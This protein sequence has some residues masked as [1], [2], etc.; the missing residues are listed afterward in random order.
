[1]NVPAL[2]HRSEV[3]LIFPV[4]Q[5]FRE[6]YMRTNLLAFIAMIVP[7][8]VTNGATADKP[9]VLLIVCDDLNRHVSTSGYAPIDT[10]ALESLA[11]AG[12]NFGRAYCQYPVCGPSRAS[13]L[14]GLYPETTR[15]LDNK[16]DIRSTRPGT[17]SLP[18]LFKE[19]GYWTAGVGKVF[20]NP[21][22]N[23]GDVAWHRFEK[24]DN[25]ENPVEARLWKA[26]EAKHGSIEVEDNRRSWRK[27]LKDNRSHIAGQTPP[28]YGPT[29]LRDD[30][31]KDGKNVRQIAEW[32]DGKTNGNK[33]FFIACGI[34]KPHVPFWAPRKYF[35]QY[36]LDSLRYRLTPADDWKHRPMLAIV[37]RYEA[38]GFEFGKENDRLRRE[39]MQAYHACVSFIDAQIGLLVE[40]LQRNGH[41]DDT[42]IVF[43]S[44]H[45]YHLGEHCLWGKVTLFEECA[46]VP[47]IVRVPGRTPVGSKTDGLVELVDIY[48]TLIDLCDIDAPHKLQGQSFVPLLDDPGHAGKDVAYTVVSRGGL[49]GRSIRTDRWRYAEWGSRDQAE[50]YDIENDPYED[51]NLAA[52]PQHQLQRR[53]MHRLLTGAHQRAEAKSIQ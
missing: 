11:A 9:N 19:H 7:L 10:P 2:L 50:L 33:P 39:Y 43:T 25:D 5:Q 35:D 21:K 31:H 3:P 18:Q 15:V 48:P 8:F 45:G 22:T 46:R 30:Q 14:S 17:T 34:Q 32:L 49:L 51:H 38:F 42:I 23:P 16:S 47:M 53:T 26:F 27:V 28:G 41:W 40:S 36:P 24:F 12:L 37:K 44:D 1:M 29:E 13:F 4:S 6:R 52:D 20:H